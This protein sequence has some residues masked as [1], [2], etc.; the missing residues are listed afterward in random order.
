MDQQIKIEL[1]LFEANLQRQR[2][3]CSE[4]LKNITM[5]IKIIHKLINDPEIYNNGVNK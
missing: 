2:K 3:E 4:I 1:I 5:A